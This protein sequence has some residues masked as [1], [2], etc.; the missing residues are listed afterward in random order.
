MTP[1]ANFAASFLGFVLLFGLVSGMVGFAVG[2]ISRRR[3]SRG[4]TR[5]IEVYEGSDVPF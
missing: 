4:P 2:W 5:T 3:A 1:D